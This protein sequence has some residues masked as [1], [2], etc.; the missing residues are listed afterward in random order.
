MQVLRE[1]AIAVV[2]QI[3]ISVL[4][5]DRFAKLLQCPGRCGMRRDIQMQQPTRTPGPSDDRLKE[6]YENTREFRVAQSAIGIV[7]NS[8]LW[9]STES[10]ANPSPAQ[11]P[12]NSDIC[13][14]FYCSK[15]G[16]AR[17]VRAQRVARVA[18][19][20]LRRLAIGEPIR[21]FFAQ[22]REIEIA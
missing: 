21:E 6:K 15:L 4:V 17:R 18:F 3:T 7:R 22:S 10:P 11:F 13:R 9:R 16:S 12:V 14:E 5:S 20:S 8:L 2:D 19:F 1:D